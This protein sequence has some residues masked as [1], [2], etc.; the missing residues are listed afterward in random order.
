MGKSKSEEVF[1]RFYSSLLEMDIH[2]HKHVS[3]TADGSP[4]MT[5]QSV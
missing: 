2:I 1:Q 5:S 3:N 4:A